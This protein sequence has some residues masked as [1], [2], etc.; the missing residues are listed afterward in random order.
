MKLIV[1]IDLDGTLLATN[2][3]LFIPAYFKSLSEKVWPQDPA[4]FGD[5][6]FKATYTGMF[7]KDTPVKTLEESFDTIFYPSIGVAKPEIITSIQSFY[8]NEFANLRSITAIK[9]EAKALVETAFADGH[10]VVISTSPFFP[11]TATL[12]RLAWAGLPADQY[13]FALVSTYEDFHFA[14][15]NPAYYAEL[16]AQLGWPKHPAVMIGNDMEQDIQPAE[17]LGIPTF[18]VDESADITSLNKHSLS[19]QGSLADVNAWLQQVSQQAF[20]N[21]F[22]S[23]EGMLAVLNATPAALETLVKNIENDLWSKRPEPAEWALNEICC[24]LRDVDREVNLP[25]IQRVLSEADAFIPGIETDS[26]AEEMDYIH[27]NGQN[28][29]QDFLKTRLQI[30]DHLSKLPLST[31][32]KSLRHAIFGPTTFRELVSFIVT[33][34]QNHVAQ[35]KKTIQ[36]LS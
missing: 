2:E 14:K 33:H 18:L 29:L 28:A 22:T 32:N 26:W 35:V 11:R 16:L 6:L 20:Q 3:Q 9:P 5:R 21:N 19:S 25:R 27:Q 23:K 24:H 8:D 30:I 10:Q 34:D 4:G 17:L 15:P 13:P 12:Q 1:L 36:Q 31:W 7:I